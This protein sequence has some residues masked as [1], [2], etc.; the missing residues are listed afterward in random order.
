[1]DKNVQTLGQDVWLKG[2]GKEFGKHLASYL[3]NDGYD[4]TTY[5]DAEFE[6]TEESGDSEE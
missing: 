3:G 2:G 4:L 6:E 1:M 5:I